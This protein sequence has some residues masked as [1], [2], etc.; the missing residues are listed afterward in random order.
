[1]SEELINNAKSLGANQAYP[2][3]CLYNLTVVRKGQLLRRQAC[4]SA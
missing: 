4:I 1:M 2:M 3:P